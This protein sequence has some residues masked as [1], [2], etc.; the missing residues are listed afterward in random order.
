MR[1]VVSCIV[2]LAGLVL[3]ISLLAIG[4]ARQQDLASIDAIWADRN[5]KWSTQVTFADPS[6]A[7]APSKQ[8]DEPQPPRTS[9]V[10]VVAVTNHQCLTP[11]LRPYRPIE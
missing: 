11:R 4:S 1:R 7:K 10:P 2:V 9:P 5:E 3:A 8:V 6:P